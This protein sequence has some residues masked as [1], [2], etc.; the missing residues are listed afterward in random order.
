MFTSCASTLPVNSYYEKAGTLQKGG[1]EISGSATRY[2]VTHYDRTEFS[3]QGGGFRAGYG[4]SDRFD[5]KLRYEKQKFSTNFDGRLKEFNMVSLVPKYALL[6]GRISIMM[7]LS[8]YKNTNE[9]YGTKYNE[10]YTS[11]APVLLFTLTNRKNIADLTMGIK[12]EFLFG[13]E[14]S[15]WYGGGFIGAGLSTNLNK[16]AIRPE[17]G[18]SRNSNKEAFWNYGIGFQWMISHRK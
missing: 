12:S 10:K 13:K 9:S 11:V 7:P 3:N 16:W 6:P 18:L 8:W 4:I 17:L 1:I 14:E 15:T 2:S 5:L